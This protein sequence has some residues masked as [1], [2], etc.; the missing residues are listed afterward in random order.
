MFDSRET[1]KT[2]NPDLFLLMVILSF[3]L[4]IYHNAYG[5]SSDR[6]KKSDATEISHNQIEVSFCSGRLL[7]AFQ[8]SCVFIKDYVKYF[9]SAKNQ[10]LQNKNVNQKVSF[11]QKF[12]KKTRRVKIYIF[13]YHNIQFEADELPLLGY[14]GIK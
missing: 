13:K 10:F 8:K 5:D 14:A 4:L 12:R 6:L 7:H 2:I 9:P 3:G 11:L 1:S